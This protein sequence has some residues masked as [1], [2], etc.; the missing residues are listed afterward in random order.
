V[1]DP[2]RHTGVRPTPARARPHAR[3]SLLCA[4]LASAPIKANSPWTSLP[5]PHTLAALN[6]RNLGREPRA[7]P[8]AEPP[9]LRPPWSA[10]PSHPSPT[11]AARLASPET[12]EA[13]QT[14]RP[15]PPSSDFLRSPESVDR[16]SHYTIFKF[17]VRTASVS[18]G[19]SSQANQLNFTIVFRLDSS[20]PTSSSA[21]ARG[22]SD[23]DHLR[24]P[25][26]H[27][28]VR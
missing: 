27:Q 6:R 17:L 22:Q 13:S 4:L 5:Q 19:K 9:E 10:H 16:V 26:A 12:R 3:S 24:P 21:L 15:R 20:P 11:P 2:G 8:P 28:R 18:P 1:F 14:L 25:S 7:P 23:S